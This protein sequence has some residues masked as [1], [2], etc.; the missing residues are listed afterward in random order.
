MRKR[1]RG[2]HTETERETYRDREGDIQRKRGRHTE[3]EKEKET[4]RETYTLEKGF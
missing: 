4:E 3:T 2:R 1:Q